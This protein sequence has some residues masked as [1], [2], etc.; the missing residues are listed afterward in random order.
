MFAGT[1]TASLSLAK[2]INVHG[3]GATINAAVTGPSFQIDRGATLRLFGLSIVNINTPDN[4]TAIS[5]Y[6]NNS[7]G[8]TPIVELEDVTIDASK[9]A[10]IAYPCTMTISRSRL[11][12]HS[13]S[14]PGIYVLPI[15]SLILDRSIVDG[16]NG[17]L[18]EGPA[19]VVR[20]TN[21]VIKNQGPNG[22][23]AGSNLGGTGAGS[24][25]V[26]FTTVIDSVVTCPSSGTPRCAGGT[27]IGSC[28]DN[29]VIYYGASGPPS[30]LVVPGTCP[31]SYTLV[32]PQ[33]TALSGDHNQLGVDP[34]LVNY[35]GADYHLAGTSPAIDAADPTA[36][37]AF[38]LDG[39]QRPVGVQRDIGAFEYK[40]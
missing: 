5:C 38:D 3:Y 21:S 13:L 10:A 8:P 19:S 17:I 29:S 26:S 39:L 22:A 34:M 4:G 23:F 31:M 33:T 25:F 27:G 30:D 14:L 24:V 40:P 11:T 32:F 15:S 28:I 2:T 18:A 9:E 35:A 7:T 6:P 37:N 36:T 1:Y 16:G 20:I 12:T